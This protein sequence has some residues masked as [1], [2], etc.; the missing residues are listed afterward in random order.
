[1]NVP[2]VSSIIDPIEY[3]L[4]EA[5][6]LAIFGLEEVSAN[7]REILGHIMKPGDLGTSDPRLSAERAYNTYKSSSEVLVG[8]LLGVTDLNYVAHK[9]CVC[10]E[11]SDRKKQNEFLEE[12][13]L[14]RRRELADRE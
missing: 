13:A 1:M 12:A 2:G 3:S 6:F 5:F 7:L 9:G 8:S 10:R 11:N 14:T 4:R